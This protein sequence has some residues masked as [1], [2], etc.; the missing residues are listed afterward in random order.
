[1]EVRHQVVVGSREFAR[2]PQTVQVLDDRL[3]QVRAH[4]NLPDSGLG[5]RVWNAEAASLRIVKADVPDLQGAELADPDAAAAEDLADEEQAWREAERLREYCDA[6]EA[7][8]GE[9]PESA[10]WIAWARDFASS[11]DPTSER[12]S[13]PEPPDETPE[14]LQE[15]LPE[16]W[17]AHGPEYGRAHTLAYRRFG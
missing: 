5:L 11:L 8:Y 10:E 15:H 4:L 12:P 1:M 6:M 16:G 14:A 9:H 2:P 7:A 13:M 3:D 17:S